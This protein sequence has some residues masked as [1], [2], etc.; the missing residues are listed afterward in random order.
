MQT[1]FLV[2]ILAVV[3]LA[4]SIAPGTAF[5]F[6]ADQPRSQI[7]PISE[8][9]SIPDPL[10][11]TRAAQRQRI[12]ARRNE[13][14]FEKRDPAQ[15]VRVP[16]SNHPYKAPTKSDKRGPCPG[17]NTLA[18]H[19]YLPRSGI[20]H[21]HDIV[22]GTA[23]GFNLGFDLATFLALFGILVD[24]D[25]LSGM[26]SIGGPT[27]GIL[28][29]GKAGL[30]NHGH[31]EGDASLTRSDEYF[32]GANYQ[33]NANL[34]NKLKS[35][36]DQ[37]GNGSATV[38]S[39]AQYRYQRFQESKADNPYF[40][41]VFPRYF[42]SYAET[43]LVLNSFPSAAKNT[44]G[45]STDLSDLSSFFVNQT[46]PDEWYRKATPFGLLDIA[47]GATEI[48]TRK[49]V[50]PGQN[51]GKGNYVPLG[52]NLSADTLT[53]QNLGCAVYSFVV[54][55]LAPSLLQGLVDTLL[56]VVDALLGDLS[57]TLEHTFDCA[58]QNIK[59]PAATAPTTATAKA[60]ATT[61]SKA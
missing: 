48:L 30:N 49:F 58:P 3:C 59:D 6:Y 34:F 44:S 26:L 42:F 56:G 52:L 13:A 14:R 46:F 60:T 27:K 33:F 35:F 9:A 21:A 39:L 24:G 55:S 25:P 11:H 1:A 10:A 17:L 40:S 37:Y 53:P 50:L 23:A 45:V 22:E 57:E 5:P 18:N 41:F 54:Q 16:D 36:N 28:G 12:L 32:N 20:V 2:R 15:L 8:R 61:A 38:D 4:I 47:V 29:G 31:F 43:S 19:G 51:S 7:V